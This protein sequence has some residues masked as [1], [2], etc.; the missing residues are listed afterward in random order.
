[1]ELLG[2][3][4]PVGDAEAIQ[5]I[6]DVLGAAGV[7]E[8]RIAVGDSALFGTLLDEAGVSAEA[9]PAAREALM[10]ELETRDLVGLDRELQTASLTDDQRSA[11]TD[12]AQARGGRE[13]LSRPGCE[14]LTALADLLDG[15]TAEPNVIFDLGLIRSQTYYTGTVFEVYAGGFGSPLGGGGRY[16]ELVGRF[17]RDLSAFGFA[18]NM[19]R[20][21]A[22]LEV[23]AK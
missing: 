6:C 18:L 4:A 14:R 13:I 16:D 15:T 17:G 1:M 22:A 21:C 12:V 11:L 5:L 3:D 8:F 2:V 9:Q 20:I 10:F 7:E 19:D 23:G